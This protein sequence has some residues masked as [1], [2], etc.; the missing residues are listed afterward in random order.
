MDLGTSTRNTGLGTRKFIESVHKGIMNSELIWPILT[1]IR[2]TP[3][4]ITFA[5]GMLALSISLYWVATAETQVSKCKSCAAILLALD[6][7]ICNTG[8]LILTLK[9]LPD[10]FLN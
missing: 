7:L 5:L 3:S 6:R 4:M 10:S 9:A 2:F 8:F 1:G